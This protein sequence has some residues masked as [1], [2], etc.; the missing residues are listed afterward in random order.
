[1]ENFK[2]FLEKRLILEDPEEIIDAVR[3]YLLDKADEIEQNEPYAINTI[4]RIREAAHEVYDI[5]ND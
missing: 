3:D 2:E 1:M 4:R 5:L